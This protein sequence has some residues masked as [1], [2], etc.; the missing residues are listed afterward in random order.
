VYYVA[1][2]PSALLLELAPLALL[3]LLVSS[4]HTRRSAL[5]PEYRGGSWRRFVGLYSN[6]QT[7]I[8]IQA[9][10]EELPGFS[11]FLLQHTRFYKLQ[12]QCR[13]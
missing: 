7:R 4:E 1:P 13:R 10:G 5:P 12:S 3:S 8:S 11:S 9:A 6:L 2:P